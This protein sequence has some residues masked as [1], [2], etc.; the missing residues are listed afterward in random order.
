[1]KKY[2][3][4]LILLSLSGCA[5]GYLEPERERLYD[6]SMLC[7]DEDAPGCIEGATI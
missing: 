2:V 4:L 3:L 7:D 6:N 1:M 5:I